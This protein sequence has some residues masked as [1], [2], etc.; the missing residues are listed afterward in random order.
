MYGC[1]END[2]SNTEA[3][4]SILARRCDGKK[5]C[6][7]TACEDM[8]GVIP[9]CEDGVKPKLWLNLRQVCLV[10]KFYPSSFLDVMVVKEQVTSTSKPKEKQVVERSSLT[11]V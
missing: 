6:S 7:G 11:Q 5:S 9:R 4:T 10:A 3:H 1:K 2:Y 8:F